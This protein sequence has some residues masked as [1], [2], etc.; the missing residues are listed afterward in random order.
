ML[1]LV[2]ALS[3]PSAAGFSPVV[4]LHSRMAVA[5]QRPPVVMRRVEKPIG[6]NPL[7]KVCDLS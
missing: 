1:L 2:A 7:V 3:L 5:P 4:P 6:K